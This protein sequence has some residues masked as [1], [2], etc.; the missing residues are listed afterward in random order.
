MFVYDAVLDKGCLMKPS[1][2]HSLDK[3]R[4]PTAPTDKGDAQAPNA[5]TPNAHTPPVSAPS[6]VPRCSSTRCYTYCSSGATA[7]T[8]AGPRQTGTPKHDE[9]TPSPHTPQQR[10]PLPEA[11]LL[12][13]QP[14]SA[15]GSLPLSKAKY[16]D[17]YAGAMTNSQILEHDFSIAENCTGRKKM[18]QETFERWM[19]RGGRNQVRAAVEEGGEGERKVRGGQPP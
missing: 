2:T 6:S 16:D 7:P 14:Q 12:L 10:P 18:G 3:R 8:T 5:Q 17:L 19:R 1:H 13:H 11:C 9:R 15:N 4:V